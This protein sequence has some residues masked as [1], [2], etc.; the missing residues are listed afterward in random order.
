LPENKL[1]VNIDKVGNTLAASVPIC[2]D[3]IVRSGKI[4]MGVPGKSGG[5]KVLF[6]AFGGGLTWGSCLWQL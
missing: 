1:H 3:E 5:Q 6:V 4:R 2:L